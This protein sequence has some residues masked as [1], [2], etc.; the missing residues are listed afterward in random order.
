MYRSIN[1]NVLHW[2]CLFRRSAAT[3]NRCI[4]Y[5][6]VKGDESDRHLFK[7]E[8]S[9]EAGT[10][11][12]EFVHGDFGRTYPC[13]SDILGDCRTDIIELDVEV[14]LLVIKFT[15]TDASHERN[16]NNWQGSKN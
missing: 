11:I 3:R 14:C 7:I 2:S 12:K 10:Y 16:T 1:D 9:T 4:Y 15:R 6:K 8:L 5:I 13:L